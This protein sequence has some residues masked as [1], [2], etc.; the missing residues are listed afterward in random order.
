MKTNLKFGLVA[1]LAV[2]VLCMAIVTGTTPFAD[3]LNLFSS[4]EDI[5]E[6]MTDS[7]NSGDYVY[8]GIGFEDIEES[9]ENFIAAYGIRPSEEMRTDEWFD[10]LYKVHFSLSNELDEV[11]HGSNLTLS[12]INE[13]G[14]PT[15]D[16]I[17][18]AAIENDTL[19]YSWG[20]DPE[21]FI[22]M[23]LNMDEEVNQPLRN[24][25]YDLY[26]QRGVELG[27]RDIPLVFERGG[28]TVFL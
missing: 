22:H 4:G 21:G 9:N 17:R 8:P 12:D 19:I 10:M 20:V 1:V 2:S 7:G 15:V 6:N 18:E 5:A 27:I 24:E 13:S 26:Y 14:K 28:P 3:G 11:G 23:D 16:E 25:I